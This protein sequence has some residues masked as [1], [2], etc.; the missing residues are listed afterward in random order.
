M[1]H[2]GKKRLMYG[3]LAA[4]I[5]L[6]YIT[7]LYLKT[8]IYL[9]YDDCGMRAI[10][11]GDM[12]G[13]PGGH[14]MFMNYVVG[15]LLSVLYRLSSVL[16]W[17]G[18][19]YVTS[20]ALA[21]WAFLYK[22][23]VLSSGLGKIKQA[24]LVLFSVIVFS[25]LFFTLIVRMTYTTL[26]AI[27]GLVVL[28]YYS[29]TDKCELSDS[30]IVV[31]LSILCFAIRYESFLMLAPYILVVIIYKFFDAE[32]KKKFI[33]SGLPLW[34][35]IVI[36]IGMLFIADRTAYRDEY[37]YAR[38]INQLRSEL[39]DKNG[40]PPYETNIDLYS[41]LNINE[42]EYNMLNISWG[43]A[44]SFTID[45]LR[46]IVDSQNKPKPSFMDLCGS[47]IKSIRQNIS[48]WHLLTGFVML[49]Y[50]F[51]LG[52]QDRSFKGVII[53]L[54]LS[55]A[56]AFMESLYILRIGRGLDYRLIYSFVLTIIMMCICSLIRNIT[57]KN[58]ILKRKD[59]YI[60]Y[61]CILIVCIILCIGQ[62]IL[63]NRHQ[64][65]EDHRYW[66]YAIED[67]FMD[68]PQYTYLTSGLRSDEELDLRF[69]KRRNFIKL[70]GWIGEMPEFN[71]AVSGEYGSV[72]EGLSERD[73]LIIVCDK[74]T[75]EAI[76]DYLGK[77]QKGDY[78]AE[79]M[80]VEFG[81]ADFDMWKIIKI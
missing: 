47:I 77:T 48:G 53:S 76:I 33:L 68:H 69:P 37:K 7:V 31:S 60:E 59:R 17:F 74:P 58:I 52:I 12:S 45:N 66:M 50:I 65:E 22:V 61:I 30:I 39:Q 14:I 24:F 81:G 49:I 21:M 15:L 79:Y 72:W 11:S 16:D 54:L 75:I 4:L 70:N 80:T 3:L 18:L 38:E 5:T 10:A 19:F 1:E 42:R 28:F 64:A 67:Y 9:T 41:G 62:V 13:T 57:C 71:K 46:V 73:D 32:N 26:A 8:T 78:S 34:M 29:L 6:I 25:G 20:L 35:T 36:G 51:I 63:Y 55:I 56:I 44:D 40:L 23:F 27:V 2:T 43:L